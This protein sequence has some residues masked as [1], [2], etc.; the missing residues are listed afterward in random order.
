MHRVGRP[1][2]YG[3]APVSKR[4]LNW[5]QRHG[6]NGR[7]IGGQ[8]EIARALRINP[9]T[10]RKAVTD[11]EKHG[12]VRRIQE[13]GIKYGIQ[14]ITNISLAGKRPKNAQTGPV[15]G[16]ENAQETTLKNKEINA[17][18]MGTSTPANKWPKK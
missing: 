12:Y 1:R 5:L 14:I 8:S 3:L 2:N 16:P 17:I 18:N 7:W 11:L 15:S 6:E 9:R 4:L 13:P 10:V